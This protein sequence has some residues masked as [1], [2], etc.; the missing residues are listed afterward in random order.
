MSTN[1]LKKTGSTF[2]RIGKVAGGLSFQVLNLVN[3]STDK[4]EKSSAWFRSY[5]VPSWGNGALNSDVTSA[6][7]HHLWDRTS[8]LI[9]GGKDLLYDELSTPE[10]VIVDDEVENLLKYC[11]YTDRADALKEALKSCNRKV[12]DLRNP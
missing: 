7:N 6:N 8:S 2:N 10:K 11:G 3:D 1:I 9:A 4:A 5:S 12:D